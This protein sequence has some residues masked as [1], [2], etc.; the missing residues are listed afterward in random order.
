MV[1]PADSYIVVNKSIITEV[2]KKIL[3]DL[4]ELHFFTTL[5]IKKVRSTRNDYTVHISQV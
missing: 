4:T 1:L 5:Q 3:V 2:D